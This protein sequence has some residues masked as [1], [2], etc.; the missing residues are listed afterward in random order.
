MKNLLKIT[1]GIAAYNEENGI[2]RTLDSLFDQQIE[3]FEIEKIIVNSDGSNDKTEELVQKYKNKKVTLLADGKRKG[4][5]LRLNEIM[6]LA[7]SEVLVLLDA[8]VIFE[9]PYVIQQMIVPFLQDEKVGLVSGTEKPTQPETFVQQI[10]YTGIELWDKTRETEY[11]SGAYY[12][13]GAIRAL[14]KKLYKK[15]QFPAIT[16][17]DVYPYLY[18]KANSCGKFVFA[19]EAGV[20]YTIPKNISDYLNQMK[21][22]L[23]S[24]PEQGRFFDEELINQ[25][26]TITGQTKLKVLLSTFVRK[27]VMVSLYM[28]LLILAR[29]NA[30]IFPIK[31]AG[32]WEA[33]SS[34][35]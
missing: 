5:A 4:K 35:K 26:F 14:R 28:L 27:P 25:E 16:A 31:K 33:V 17:E 6:K 21:R 34:S 32:V 9:S 1:I 19:P 12:C 29:L 13:S 15:I 8:D 11:G 10:L 7:E 24:I 23:S 18:C 30:R 22:Y 2:I 20:L 3:K